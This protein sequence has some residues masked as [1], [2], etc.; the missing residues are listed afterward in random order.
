MSTVAVLGTGIV[1]ITLATGFAR[2]GHTVLVGSGHPDRPQEALASAGVRVA[3]HADAAGAADV[4]FN[5]TPGEV[6]AQ[7]LGGL[8]PALRGR[9]LADVSN[10]A[11]RGPDG[12]PTGPLDPDTSVAEE[13]QRALPD[14]RVVKTLN[15]MDQRVMTDPSVLPTPPTAFLA[16]DD[17]T[18]K[19]AVT[20][21]LHDVGW[22]DDWLL[23]LGPLT[24]AR[25]LE[26]SY[27]MLGPIIRRH[28]MAPFSL[29]IAH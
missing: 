27:V 25:A 23:D 18:A 29:A 5:A 19:A 20:A 9:V 11:V 1:G 14:T 28:G 2:A 8:A 16:G 4:V 15:T 12:F 21:L 26:A 24:A 22:H 13:I 6:A 3:A 10:A 17:P 7:F